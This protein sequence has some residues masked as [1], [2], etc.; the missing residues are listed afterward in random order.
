MMVIKLKHQK[1]YRKIADGIAISGKS[2]NDVR[3]LIN[4]S[5]RSYTIRTNR[6]NEIQIITIHFLSMRLANTNT[7]SMIQYDDN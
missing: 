7:F 4:G 1:L 2:I 3:E 6:T 5:G